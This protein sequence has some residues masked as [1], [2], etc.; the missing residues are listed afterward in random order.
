MQNAT[1]RIPFPSFKILLQNAL[2]GVIFVFSVLLV[3]QK[4]DPA[5]TEL[6]RDSGAYI[7]IGSHILRGEAP[8]LTAWDSKPPGIFLLDAA[9]LWIGGG[10]RWGIWLI[11]FI[12]LTAAVIFG[13]LAMRETFGVV[14]ALMAS[15][16]W[17]YV[18]NRL[19]IGGNLT[20]E[21]ALFFGFLSVLLFTLSF[22]KENTFWLDIGI[23]FCAGGSFLFRPNNAGVQIAIVLTLVLL[24]LQKKHY[25]VLLKRLVV[26]GLAALLPLGIVAVYLI[27]KNVL[28]A[29]W[30]A[31]IIYNFFSYAGAHHFNLSGSLLMGI[32]HI[33]FI[34]HFTFL[35]L[36][37]AISQLWPK[38]GEFLP[39][40]PIA[41][42]IF[43]NGLIEMAFSGLS[44]RNYE[45]YFI[46]W[47]PFIAFSNALLITHIFPQISKWERK[48]VLAFLIIITALLGVSFH[49]G[50][51]T[52]WKSVSTSH[53]TAEYADPVAEYVRLNTTRDE[54]VL[55]WGGQA[56]INFLAQRD[57][58]V[59][60]LFFP[61][62]VQSRVTDRLSENYYRDITSNPPKLIVDGNTYD[63][64]HVI[65]ISVA[66]PIAWLSEHKIYETPYLLEVLKFIRENYTLVK[67]INGID[68]YRLN[69][70]Y[71]Q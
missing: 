34:V 30:E 6:G 15:L 14:A 3:L 71:R 50:I 28:Q 62:G 40:F 53:F 25:F 61:L 8:Y 67:N 64:D 21:Y 19:L 32:F 60:Y 33:G 51:L 46:N 45:H 36:F 55:V 20:E 41:L 35:G 56:G 12:S 49:N 42:L 2:I 9:G 16:I 58:P 52:M 26:I 70:G 65:P 23:G 68:I 39:N 31:A 37:V 10:T 43:I 66:E 59:S 27:S 18:L 22:K 7:Y 48:T 63:L 44:G 11:E 5:H 38:T 1:P 4:A 69:Q 29:S 17:L 13:F 54:T 57:S 47:I 24:M